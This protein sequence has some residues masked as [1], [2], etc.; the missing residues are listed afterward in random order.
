MLFVRRCFATGLFSA[1]LFCFNRQAVHRLK[2]PCC[3][4][5][6]LSVKA[7]PLAQDAQPLGVLLLGSGELCLE[8]CAFLARVALENR[9]AE[10][11][12]DTSDAELART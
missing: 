11:F 12:R 10:F 9:R 8:A 5:A 1:A 2:Y 3:L 4:C 7:L 6:L